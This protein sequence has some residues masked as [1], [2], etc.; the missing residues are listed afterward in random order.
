M[1]ARSTHGAVVSLTTLSLLMLM[2]A[3]ARADERDPW[4][5]RDKALHFSASAVIAGGAY[6]GSALFT[7][8]RATRAALGVGV[9]L[10]AGIA[11]EVYDM[12]GRGDP[13]W[14]DLTWDAIGVTMGVGVSLLIDWAIR[15]NIGQDT[16]AP[17][18]RAALVRW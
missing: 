10:A 15:G 9:G 18:T 5:G 12:T 6:G 2:P 3:S 11:K 1:F 16:T 4:L 8:D 13:S 17:V 7:D 14:R